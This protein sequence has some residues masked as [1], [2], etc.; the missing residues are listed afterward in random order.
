MTASY[1]LGEGQEQGLVLHPLQVHVGVGVQDLQALEQLIIQ[2][3]NEAHQVA[4]NLHVT[5]GVCVHALPTC[6]EG[7][8]SG[9]H[10]LR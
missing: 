2:S 6:K 9:Q 4:P 10:V 5:E 3:L 8:L 7:R 1:L